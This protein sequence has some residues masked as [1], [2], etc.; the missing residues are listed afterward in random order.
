MSKVLVFVYLDGKLTVP[1]SPRVSVKLEGKGCFV[2]QGRKLYQLA[3][4]NNF[5]ARK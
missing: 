2:I 1:R 4:E 3:S 5:Y